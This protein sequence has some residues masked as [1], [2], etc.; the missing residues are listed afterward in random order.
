MTNE[1]PAAI[2]AEV[3]GGFLWGAT[4]AGIK[5][6]GNPDLAL[7]TASTGTI[8]AAMLTSTRVAAATITVG[9]SHLASS[10]QPRSKSGT[11]DQCIPLNDHSL[12]A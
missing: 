6:S 8:G 5:A 2:P 9:S 10:R 7:A 3:P 4:T 11:G 1:T 12:T